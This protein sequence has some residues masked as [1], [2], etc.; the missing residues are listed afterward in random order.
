GARGD[1]AAKRWSRAAELSRAGMATS[2]AARACNVNVLPCLSYLAQFFSLAPEIWRVEFTMPR[3]LLRFPPSPMRTADALAMGAWR[4]SPAPAGV[5]PRSAATALRAA[6]RAARGWAPALRSLRETAVEHPPLLDELPAPAPPA[7]VEA[8]RRAM[9]DEEL[10]A[11]AAAPPRKVKRQA[12]AMSALGDGLYDDRLDLLIGRRLRRWG[13]EIP[14]E[15]PRG[16]SL[17]PRAVLRDARPSWLRSRLR[18]AVNG[19]I[20]S[21]RMHV[22]APRP[23]IFGCDAK[24]DLA[25]YT[26]CEKLRSAV[27]APAEPSELKDGI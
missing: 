6:A 13:V 27:A 16:R 8:A 10:A 2:L 26:I 21:G 20:T 17:G 4:G 3:R 24:G 23:R 7:P 25:L 18:A 1:A 14:P 19:W 22:T 15:E 12:A 9:A 11:A 5:P